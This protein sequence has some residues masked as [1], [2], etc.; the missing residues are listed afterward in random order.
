M[1]WAVG[2]EVEQDEAARGT[3]QHGLDLVILVG[4]G[5]VPGDIDGATRMPLE[6]GLQ[7]L[8]GLAAAL[9]PACDDDALAR[10]PVD[11]AEA[12]APGWLGRRGDH[13]LPPL[14]APERPE[15]WEPADI[16]L[17]GVVEDLTLA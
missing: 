1:P 7:Q 2:R 16:E 15:C 10:A 11:R 3:A 9:V 6:E 14:G 12:I 5:V 17:V 13:H 8:G 4:V